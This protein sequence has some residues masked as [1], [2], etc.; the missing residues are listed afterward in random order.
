[1]IHIILEQQVSIASA[2]AA[3]DRLQAAIAPI[4]PDRFLQL[5]EV[6]LKQIGF[7]RQKTQ[8][9]RL[10]AQAILNQQLDLSALVQ[11][12]DAQVRRRLTTLKGIGDWTVD[13]YLLMALRRPDALPKGDL[14]LA[15]A[16]QQVKGLSKRPTHLELEAIAEQWRPWR[17]VATRLLWHYYLS[18][19]KGLR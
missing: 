9:A 4:T 18:D 3:F 19:R 1:L 5:D 11:L 16:V 17:A 8:Y 7:S 2:Q 13:I 15:I 6:Q 12:E 14:A 10:L